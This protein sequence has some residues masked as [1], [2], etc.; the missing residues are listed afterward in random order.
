[1]LIS[2]PFTL[3][4]V[5]LPIWNSLKQAFALGIQTQLIVKQNPK[6]QPPLPLDTQIKT[7]TFK[8]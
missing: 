3:M 7:R 5:I 6:L 2:Q 4:S 8:I 1:M